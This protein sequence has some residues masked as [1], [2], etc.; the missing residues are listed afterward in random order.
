MS[1][2]SMIS[3]SSTLKDKLDVVRKESLSMSNIPYEGVKTVF[4]NN[5]EEVTIYNFLPYLEEV[6]FIVE[7]IEGKTTVYMTYSG[8]IAKISEES[9]NALLEN[10]KK[11]VEL[12]NSGNYTVIN[13]LDAV[14]EE[15]KIS[16][17]IMGRISSTNNKQD[18]LYQEY[19]MLIKKLHLIQ[20]QNFN[21][22]KDPQELYLKKR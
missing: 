4:T 8:I 17:Q 20:M 22:Y 15:I 18:L 10:V 6:I 9:L 5:N 12:M 2:E 13:S 3:L 7:K 14:P 21:L 19:C 16:Y 1:I 11:I